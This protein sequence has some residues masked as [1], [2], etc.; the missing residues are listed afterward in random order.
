MMKEMMWMVVVVVG[1]SSKG[2]SEKLMVSFASL[3]ALAPRTAA[4]S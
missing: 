1:E 4:R 3:F 2:K